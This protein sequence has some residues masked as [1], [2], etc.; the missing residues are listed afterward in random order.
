MTYEDYFSPECVD[1]DFDEAVLRS[2]IL[3]MVGSQSDRHDQIRKRLRMAAESGYE[4]HIIDMAYDEGVSF[5]TYDAETSSTPKQPEI[6]RTFDITIPPELI[7]NSQQS[8]S[9]VPAVLRQPA[10]ANPIPSS[11]S[12]LQTPSFLS[13]PTTHQKSESDRTR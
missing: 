5:D 7:K 4:R 9:E 8:T 13:K 2:F 10:R 1:L 11:V 6:L 12:V 3:G